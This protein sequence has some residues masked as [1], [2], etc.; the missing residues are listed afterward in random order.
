MMTTVLGRAHIEQ[1]HQTTKSQKGKRSWRCRGSQLHGSL[2]LP[3]RQQLAEAVMMSP[4]VHAPCRQRCQ[5]PAQSSSRQ[6]SALQ[7]CPQA[8]SLA[9]AQRWGGPGCRCPLLGYQ[10]TAMLALASDCHH[11]RSPWPP[12]P[13][14]PGPG[15]LQEAKGTGIVGRC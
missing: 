3:A 12:A 1:Q 15:T 7:C 10:R 11:L 2:A 6:C 13:G 14:Q 4:T 9:G 5:F 8:C